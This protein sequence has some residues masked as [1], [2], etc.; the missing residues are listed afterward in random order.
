MKTIIEW[1]GMLPEPLKSQAFANAMKH[2]KYDIFTYQ[3]SDMYGAIDRGMIWSQ[4]AEGET[5]WEDVASR[6]DN[7]T[8]TL[9]IPLTFSS[10]M[11]TMLRSMRGDC[12]IA[13]ALLKDNY[14]HTTF[15]NYITM[16]GELCS[17]LP[18]G[19]EHVVNDMGKWARNGRQDMKV[20]KMA[21]NLLTEYSLSQ[22]GIEATDF[23]KFTNLVKSYISVIGDEDGEGKKIKFEVVN[24]T[25]LRDAYYEDNYSNILGTDTNL[26]NS[27]MRYESCQD[28]LDIYV[29]NPD[30]ISL[31]VAYDSNNMVL[32]RAILWTMDNGEK[33]MDTIYAH[34]TLT[35]SFI[36][37][38]NDNDYFYKSRQ[39]CHHNEFDKH[40]TNGYISS[41]C[42]TLKKYRF[43][44]Y[45][46]MDTLSILEGNKLRNEADGKDYKILKSTDG[47]FEEQENSVYDVFNNCDIHEDDAFYVSYNR[48]NGENIEGYI[49]R[50]NAIRTRTEWVLFIDCVQID[51][52][53]YLLDDE[54]ITYIE[55]R[56]EWCLIEDCHEDYNGEWIHEDDSV[57]L[58][59][60][61]YAHEDEASK[62]LFDGEYYIN[63]DMTEF[64]GG[65]VHNGNIDA[66]HELKFILNTKNTTENETKIA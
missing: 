23:E 32:G 36:Q 44:E 64:D 51:R 41:P 29:Y 34:E 37:W 48:P 9:I 27:C 25:N 16:R 58:Y 66:Y 50:D 7:D 47:S 18:N 55:S 22:N 39:S 59:D 21:R 1:Y 53:Y 45:P 15:A 56:N 2:E 20:A 17:Y 65:M 8:N 49:H 40:L 30:V 61:E 14:T 19:R 3:V 46:Y 24:G 11:R 26:W 60:G 62:C 42:V 13:N 4:C 28:Y 63:N 5:F 38:A 35:A 33:A 12:K 10:S 6:W 57:E 43:D 31:L 54:N 52:V